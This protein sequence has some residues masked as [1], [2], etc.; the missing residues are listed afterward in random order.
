MIFNSFT[1]IFFLVAVVC[2][3]WSLNRQARLWMLLA[4]SVVFYG[5][6]NFF[7]VPLLFV[8]IGVDYFAARYMDSTDERRHRRWAMLLSI[9]V[10]FSLL[11]FF[12]YYFFFSS[13]VIM[14]ASLAGV[15]LDMPVLNILLPIG[16]S[17]YTFQSV[18]YTI[19]VYRRQQK[20]VRDFVLFAN[21]V[22]FFP[23]LVAGPILRAGEM[24]WQL[25]RRPA[26]DWNSI[27]YGTMRILGGLALKVLLADTIAGSVN[28]GFA[29]NPS[30]LSAID[31]TTLAFL[32][33]FQIYFDFAAYSHIALGSAR[34]M[35]IKV[36][37]NFNFP[38]S[39][40]SPRDFWRRWHISLSSWIRDYLY[41]P[42]MGGIPD[43]Y[44]TG[45]IGEQ[46]VSVG[47]RRSALALVATWAIMGLWHGA[48][49]TFVVWG[50]W[51]AILLLTYRWLMQVTQDWS[52]PRLLGWMG[53][54]VS[55]Y[56][57]M[58][59]WIPFRAEGLDVTFAMLGALLDPE[60]WFY[61]GM[62]ENTYLITAIVFVMVMTGPVFWRGFAALGRAR[63]LLARAA[64]W[65]GTTMVV[66]GVLVYLRP[67]D[68]FIYFQF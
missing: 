18:S 67:L 22:T 29:M 56:F 8:S 5:F 66:A 13:N 48:A 24:V 23:Q 57:L 43:S 17:F 31:V 50:L 45:G 14:A 47:K 40:G 46:R 41:V 27:H 28:Q 19:D 34:L 54:G 39:A 11:G 36:T 61:L 7:Y 6:W 21:Y 51:H 60:R 9:V 12:K 30:G 32:F 55:L 1:Y 49:W 38:Y 33:G 3:Y 62:R 68:Q 37:E 25:D 35:G 64:V 52:A 10:N 63:S 44:S 15:T 4:A 26:F 42:L 65:V 20:P 53:A 16:I 59:G 58:L 2:L